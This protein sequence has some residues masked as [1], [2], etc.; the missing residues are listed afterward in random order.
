MTDAIKSIDWIMFSA[1]LALSALGLV[2][3]YSFSGDNL[4]F[5]RQLVWVLLAVAVFF[6]FSTVDWQFLRRTGVVVSIFV[7]T[8]LLL[9]FLL[10]SGRVIAGSQRWLEIGGFTFQVSELAKLAII[11]LLAKYFTKRHVE[12]AHFR[13]VIVSGLYAFIFFLLIFLQPDLGTAMIIV[14]IW[15]GMILVSGISKT[16]LALVFAVGLLAF[17]GMWFFALEPH[18][19]DRIVTFFQPYADVQ[20][21]GY[22]ILQSTIAVGSG[23]LFGKGIGYGTQSHLR[24]LPEHETD[25]IFA[26]FAEEWGFV[27]VLTVFALFGVVIWRILQAALLG[28][29]NFETYF[30]IGVS[31]FLISHIF[32]HIG[33]NVGLLP[34]TGTTLPFMSFGGSNLIVAFA[35]LGMLMGMRRYS[36][37]LRYEDMTKESAMTVRI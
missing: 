30:G 35:A 2:T 6:F 19:K 27:G 9:I 3:M 33:A 7:G 22:H 34:V 36:R 28:N 23:Q 15:F 17:G 5:E 24:F 32:I 21:S 20:G 37:V 13:H 29:S 16:H 4:F 14:F 25:F 12:I 31:L 11:I 10:M 18:Q 1:V 8:C 26:A